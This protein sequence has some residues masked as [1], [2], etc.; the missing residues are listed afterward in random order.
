VSVRIASGLVICALMACLS[1]PASAR[2]T[3]PEFP[4][5]EQV[6]VRVNLVFYDVE[7]GTSRALEES[8]R[9]SGPI[10]YDAETQVSMSTFW[11]YEFVGQRCH[12]ATVDISLDITI[13]YPNWT[14]FERAS[15][16]RRARWERR[17]AGL[18]VHENGH[19]ALAFAGALDLHNELILYGQDVDCDSFE[20]GMQA[21]ADAAQTALRRRHREYDRI[22]QHGVRQNAYDWTPI[23]G[24]QPGP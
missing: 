16:Q 9:F 19:A 7:G 20:D 1:G 17:I 12:V 3:A 6:P 11:H 21:I 4:Y 10:G 5:V 15:R 14:G 13:R 24:P 18:E 2:Q 23:T 8:I 22:T